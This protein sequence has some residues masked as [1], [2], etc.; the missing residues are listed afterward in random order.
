MY[1]IICNARNGQHLGI[2]NLAL[3]DRKLTKESWWTSDDSTLILNYEKKT[4]AEFA[5]RRLKRNN[6]RVVLF[7]EACDIIEEQNREIS[8]HEANIACE[9]GTFGYKNIY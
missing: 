4:A 1:A 5:C 3:V 7:K 6:P 8:N 9:E 2:T